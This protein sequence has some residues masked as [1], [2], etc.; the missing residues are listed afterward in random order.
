MTE[1]P[2][3]SHQPTGTMDEV[4]GSRGREGDPVVATTASSLRRLF[5]SYTIVYSSEDTIRP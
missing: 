4:E 3:G 1:V 5:I 2:A